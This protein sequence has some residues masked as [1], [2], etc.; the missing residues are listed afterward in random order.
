MKSWFVAFVWSLMFMIL[1]VSIV[2]SWGWS[3]D[4]LFWGVMGI[5]GYF[6]LLFIMDEYFKE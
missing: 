6:A 2:S 3:L 5:M 4:P 1:V